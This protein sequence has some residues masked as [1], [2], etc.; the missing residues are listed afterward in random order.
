MDAE[1]GSSRLL[2]KD[3]QVLTVTKLKA[4]LKEKGLPLKGIKVLSNASAYEYIY[5]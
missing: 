4:M 3:L 5:C 1:G 2:E